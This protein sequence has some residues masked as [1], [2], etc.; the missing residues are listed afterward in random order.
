MWDRGL[1]L[2]ENPLKEAEWEIENDLSFRNSRTKLNGNILEAELCL[3]DSV[4]IG[5]V[6][7]K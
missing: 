5:F 6:L 7:F 2:T 3:T 4:V 1:L